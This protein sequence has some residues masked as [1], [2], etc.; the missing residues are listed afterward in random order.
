MQKG[1][2][3]HEEQG[4]ETSEAIALHRTETNVVELNS[5]ADVLVESDVFRP[6]PKRTGGKQ[7]LTKES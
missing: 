5:R 1:V 7:R 2:D 6:H 4:F 3:E